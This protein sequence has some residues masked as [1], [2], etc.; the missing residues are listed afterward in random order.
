MANE[1]A[2][3]PPARKGPSRLVLV[4]TLVALLLGG[5]AVA[6]I[7]LVGPMLRGRI[8]DQ[9]RG[10]GVELAFDGVTF[11][12]TSA[13]LENATFRL[14]GVPGLTGHVENLDVSL[15][16]F[17]PARFD[18]TNVHVDVVGSAADLAVALGEWTK[19]HPGA[20]RIPVAAHGLAVT[21]KPSAAEPAWLSIEGGAL[22]ESP[23]G[24]TFSAAHAMVS[25]VD[26]GSVGAAWTA[27][28]ASV[29]M[30]FGAADTASAPVKVV[31]QHAATPPT[32]QI[33]LAP[34]PLER[35]AG[36]WGIPLPAPGVTASGQVDLTF[37]RGLEAGPV[38]GAV[39][40]RLDD[41]VPP[42]PVELDG[43]LFGTTTTF[44]SRLDVSAS[45]STVQL[46]GSRVRAGAFDL[47]GTGRIDRNDG[48]AT[49][50]MSLAGNLPCAAVAESAAAAHV[51]SFIAEMIGSAAKR[52]VDGSVSVKV[53]IS[54]DSRYLDRARVEPVIGVGCGLTPI[55]AL[56]PKVLSR[57]PGRLQDFVK[58]LPDLGDFQGK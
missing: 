47:A 49:I 34:T 57:L 58:G 14:V 53:R 29:S 46:S 36:P 6:S 54:A 45:R 25:G 7:F 18:G 12:W 20:Y 5:G 11:W 1:T 40:A 44:T 22:T 55:R 27:E 23:S 41:W 4:T 38:T 13:S 24:A 33:T 50:S 42:H 19:N 10:L 16:S 56:D 26:V 32:A 17:E 31:V 37:T 48:F 39:Q 2:A 21:W 8:V 28:A 30:G 52:V 9:A 43:F 35:L 3:S 51:G 15:A